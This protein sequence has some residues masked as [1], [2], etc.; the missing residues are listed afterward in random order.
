[1]E[2]TIIIRSWWFPYHIV[3]NAR[4]IRYNNIY[5]FKYDVRWNVFGVIKIERP[6]VMMHRE[7]FHDSK[8]RPVNIKK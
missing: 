8:P 3:M 7:W 4:Y 1:M 6:W 5:P 2:N